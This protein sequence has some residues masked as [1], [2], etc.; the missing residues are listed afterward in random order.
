[1]LIHARVSQKCFTEK[2]EI[3]SIFS[4]AMKIIKSAAS[5]EKYFFIML[6]IK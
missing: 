3:I 1:M 2:N 5:L 4:K 6:K